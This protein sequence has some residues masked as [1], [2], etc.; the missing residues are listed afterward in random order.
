MSSTERPTD[1]PP[2]EGTPEADVALVVRRY[3]EAARLDV[4]AFRDYQTTR[5]LVF[6]FVN[7]GSS[8]RTLEVLQRLVREMAGR[9]VVLDL[10]RNSG[11]AEAVRQ[12]MLAALGWGASV[13]GFWDA[14]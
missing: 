3:N 9:A 10:Q 14:D 13:V 11:K 2:P 7:D 1:A 12:G 4:A 8:D 5:R 6:C